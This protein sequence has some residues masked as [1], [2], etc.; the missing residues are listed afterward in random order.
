[1][2]ATS[3]LMH[4]TSVN[5]FVTAQQHLCSFCIL[6]PAFPVGKLKIKEP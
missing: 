1:M 3:L 6:N 2:P 4:V 5:N